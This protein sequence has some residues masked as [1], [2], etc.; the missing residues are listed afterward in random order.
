MFVYQNDKLYVLSDDKLVGVTITPTQ[1]ILNDVAEEY[2]DGL[3]LT[4]QEVYA[5]FGIAG[6][7]SY[8]FPTEGEK[9]GVTKSSEGETKPTTR[10]RKPKS[11]D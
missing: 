10:G 11:T 8:V 9:H 3:V 4:I 7:Q 2:V 5:K 6:G 1:H